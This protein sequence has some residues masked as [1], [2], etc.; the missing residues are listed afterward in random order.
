MCIHEFNL[1]WFLQQALLQCGEVEESI[2]HFQRALRLLNAKL[3]NSKPRALVEITSQA[4]R[5]W[6]HIK[7]PSRFIGRQRYMVH[8]V[9]QKYKYTYLFCSQRGGNLLDQA[10]CM[11]LLVHAYQLQ[12]SDVHTLMVALRQLNTV[13]EAEEDIHQVHVH[14]Y[15]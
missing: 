7:F 9:Y 4:L 6:L 10:H 8:M 5:Q 15:K 2:P 11:S 14:V 3:P 1:L 13:E 12:N